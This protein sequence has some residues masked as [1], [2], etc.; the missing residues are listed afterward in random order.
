MVAHAPLQSQSLPQGFSC[1]YQTERNNALE[2][3]NSERDLCS[4]DVCRCLL[5]LNNTGGAESAMNVFKTSA[6]S[7]LKPGVKVRQ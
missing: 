1:T 2:S 3:E 5:L 7:C 4:P 6:R